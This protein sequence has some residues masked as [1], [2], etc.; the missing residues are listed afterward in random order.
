MKACARKEHIYLSSFGRAYK[1]IQLQLKNLYSEKKDIHIYRTHCVMVRQN[2]LIIIVFSFAFFCTHPVPS[3]RCTSVRYA[4]FRPFKVFL[5]RPH[6]TINIWQMNI[7]EHIE[8]KITFMHRLL[9]IIIAFVKKIF[10]N[11]KC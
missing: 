11:Y 4:F 5:A 3:P 6:R 8:K 1:N 10:C 9:L 7:Q 2:S